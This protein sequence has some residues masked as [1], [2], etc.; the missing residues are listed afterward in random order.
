MGAKAPTHP[1]ALGVIDVRLID[2]PARHETDI[3]ALAK[4]FGFALA[5]SIIHIDRDDDRDDIPGEI[6]H[7]RATAVITPGPE[8]LGGTDGVVRAMLA[9]LATVTPDRVLSRGVFFTQDCTAAKG[10]AS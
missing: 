9:V 6:L 1:T 10:A 4:R 8:H 7:R 5:P 2:H 3:A